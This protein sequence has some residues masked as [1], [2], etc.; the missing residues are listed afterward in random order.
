MT[1]LFLSFFAQIEIMLM[2]FPMLQELQR[3]SNVTIS[4][5]FYFVPIPVLSQN[6]TRVD[7]D[8]PSRLSYTY[9]VAFSSC[10]ITSALNWRDFNRVLLSVSISYISS[11]QSKE[12]FF[13]NF[14]SD[15]FPVW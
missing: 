13:T 6:A 9:Q 14:Y 5:K 11:S 7:F 4:T 1:N 2:S 8:E 10:V 15:V 3:R 12:V